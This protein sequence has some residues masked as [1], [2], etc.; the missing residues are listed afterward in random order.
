MKLF[1]TKGEQNQMHKKSGGLF[2]GL[3]NRVLF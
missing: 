3:E 2:D 1:I